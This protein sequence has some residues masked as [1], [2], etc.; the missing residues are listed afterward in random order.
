MHQTSR[1][2]RLLAR[3]ASSRRLRLTIG[4]LLMAA[5]LV[6]GV[7]VAGGGPGG[8][9]D[10]SSGR[11]RT[12]YI[13]ADSVRWN[14]AP[15]GRNDITG[16]AWDAAAAVFT[17]P[18][19]DRIGTTYVK[20]L[21]REYTDGTFHTLK[22]RPP[23]WEHLGN[24]GPVIHAVVGDEVRIVFRNNLARPVSVHMHG[25]RYDKASEGA[26]YQDGSLPGDRGDDAVPP[27]G[28]YTYDYTVPDRAG[29]GP[30]D[31]SSVMW[32]YHSHTDEVGDTYSGLTGPVVVTQRGAAR[33]DGTPEDVDREL[34]ALFQVSDENQSLDMP[35]NM[36]SLSRP[37]A[38]GDE[39]FGE[40]NL[41]HS[42]NGYVYGNLPLGSAPGEGVTVALG[43]R[44]RWYLLAM[45]TEVDLHTPHWHGNT[46]VANGM[47][48]DV[49]ALLPAQMVIADM[50]PD[51]PGVWLLHCHVNDHLIAG[52][53]ARYQ[54]IG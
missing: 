28:T 2:P 35:A 24:L 52:M 32:M 34:I 37:P 1:N 5:I 15:H 53:I 38:P 30:M 12:Y 19:P 27:G 51:A 42:I 20:S 54:V 3:S 40:S 45:G 44:V 49:T 10:E 4:V 11:L 25:L 43:E 8:A 6:A 33:R 14:Y 22:P 39:E 7:I 36:A 29:P 17:Q 21:Y 50:T 47:R 48:T 23:A 18:G 31:P 9:A 46:V 41:M 13:A 26:P 16:Q